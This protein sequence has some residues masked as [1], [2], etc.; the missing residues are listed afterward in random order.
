M[1]GT[2]PGGE[3]IVK[4]YDQELEHLDN[5]IIK[6]GGLTESQIARAVDA[7][8]GRDPGLAAKVIGD[9]DRIDEINY[10]IDIQA[11]RLLALRQPMAQDLRQIVA[12]LKISSDLERIGDYAAN[13][14]KRS[15]ALA[16]AAPVP[17]TSSISRMSRMAQ[18]MVQKVLDAY[19]ARDAGKALE[20]WHADE[21]LDNM[22]TSMFREALTY[23]M[24]DPRRITICA[25]LL[26]I[27]KNV[28]RIGDHVTNVAETIH[29]LVH[30]ERMRGD[31]PKGKSPDDFGAAPGAPGE[32]GGR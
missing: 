28:E 6:M 4:S 17:P 5:D 14:A 27:A 2:S 29:F 16:S 21:T 7:V 12:A 19:I 18:E 11:T 22:Y 8:V 23:M 13:I 20:V 10:E 30:G 26:F 3:H 1:A 9:D 32:A 31:R 24:E 25:N 15:I